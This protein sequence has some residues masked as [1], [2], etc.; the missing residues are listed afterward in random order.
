VL[1]GDSNQNNAY[2]SGEPARFVSSSDCDAGSIIR[3]TNAGYVWNGDPN[4]DGIPNLI[5]EKFY[6]HAFYLNSGAPDWDIN[7]LEIRYLYSPTYRCTG[8]DCDNVALDGIGKLGL[9]CA[10]TDGTIQDGE[11]IAFGLNWEL[12]TVTFRNNELHHI[13]A[14]GARMN[15]NC[16]DLAGSST[17]GA[18]CTDGPVAINIEDNE[19]WNIYAF[20][21]YHQCKNINFRRNYVHDNMFG[22]QSE[23]QTANVLVEDKRG[24]VPRGVRHPPNLVGRLA[25]LQ[26]RHLPRERR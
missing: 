8:D 21:N 10:G 5:I 17:E 14:F 25:P 9:D 12:G 16:T 6:N 7:G 22:I 11:G 2:D 1:S 26:E 19:A 20:A 4:G 3:P 13:C 18:G 24:C 15:G 23:E